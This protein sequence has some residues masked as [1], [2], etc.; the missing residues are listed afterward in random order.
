VLRLLNT[1]PSFSEGVML[2]N[3]LDDGASIRQVLGMFFKMKKLQ[4]TRGRQRVLI[5]RDQKCI[6]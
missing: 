2:A 4:H 5:K 1:Y 6:L 3:Q